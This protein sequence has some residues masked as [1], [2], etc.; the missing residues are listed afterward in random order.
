M[1]TV[2]IASREI[3]T[4]GQDDVDDGVNISDIDL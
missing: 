3:T 1:V 2:Y 4:I